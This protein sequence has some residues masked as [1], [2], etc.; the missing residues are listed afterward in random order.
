MFEQPCLPVASS[1]FALTT[2]ANTVRSSPA[3]VLNGMMKPR[4]FT[5]LTIAQSNF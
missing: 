2:P 5:L 4:S 3:W 1:F